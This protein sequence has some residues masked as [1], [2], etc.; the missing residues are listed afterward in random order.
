MDLLFEYIY[1]HIQFIADA[2]ENLVALWMRIDFIRFN[3]TAR[4]KLSYQG[5]IGGKLIQVAVP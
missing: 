5:M 2:A 3:Q 4:D 1:L